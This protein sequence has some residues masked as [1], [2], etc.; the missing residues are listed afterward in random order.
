MRRF[1]PKSKSR[2]LPCRR[3][4]SDLIPEVRGNFRR[5]V[6]RFKQRGGAGWLLLVLGTV[7]CL[8]WAGG[9]ANDQ[10]RDTQ[11]TARMEELQ[12]TE[13]EAVIIRAAQPVPA[14]ESGT[15]P[16]PGPSVLPGLAS[17]YE[18]NP[19]LAGWLKIEG[20]EI[21]YPVMFSPLD[22]DYYLT[23]NFDKQSDKNGSLLIQKECDPFKPGTNIIIHGHHMKSGKMF[24]SLDGYKEKSYWLKH[25]TIRFDTLYE[26][27]EYEIIAVFLSQVYNK[28]EDVFKYYQFFNADTQAEFDDFYNN[29]KALALYDTGVDANFGDT[30]ITLST[31]SYHTENGRLVVVARKT[32][33]TAE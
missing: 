4:L 26:Q 18:Q 20:T 24:A 16:K 1:T 13:S 22:Q 14:S 9:A 7:F 10:W 17:L 8:I 28:N 23:H 6:R 5:G 33:K 31:C 25:P 30:F 32:G 19:N 12:K 15:L 29:I 3:S 11:N 27:G 21:D 2:E